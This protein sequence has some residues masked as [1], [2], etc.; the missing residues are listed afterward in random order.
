MRTQVIDL[1]YKFKPRDYQLPLLKALDR[2]VKRAFTLWHRRS[3]KDICLW[4]YIIRR[5]FEEKGLY[6]YLLPTYS[7]ARKII[8]DGMTNDGMKFLD[9]APNAIVKNTN[10]TEMKLELTNGSI[11]QLVGTDDY[12]RI[13]GTNPRGC[14]FSEFAFHNPQAWDVIKPILKVNGGWGVFQTTP[15]GK[16]FA[17]DM[18]KMATELPDWF[19]Q[20]LTIKDTGILTDEDIRKE[21]LEGMPD[22]MIAQEYFCE[23]SVGAFG[24]YYSSLLLDAEKE[25]RICNV[26]ADPN[27]PVNLTLDLGKNDS[28]AIIFSQWIGKEIRI[29]DAFE[30]TGESVAFYCKELDKRNYRYGVMYLPHDAKAGRMESEKTIQQQFDDAGFRTEIV[31]KLEINDGIQQLRK[32]FNRIWFDKTKC[33]QLLRSLENYHKEWD[34]VRKVFKNNPL[35]DWSSN[36]ADS[37]RYLAVAYNEPIKYEE[38][39]ET[40]FDRYAL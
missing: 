33:S 29:V 9:Y 8:W 19:A 2:G 26:P 5:A 22:D 27:V 25:G 38:V 10:S 36:F 3:G 17:Y 4:N 24:S 28:T 7:Q 31:P 6:Y 35:H 37:S 39:Y 14:V 11:V 13:R 20:K 23:F 21:K 34:D 32:I 16:N 15:N 18:Y 1:P 30:H 12:D 40:K